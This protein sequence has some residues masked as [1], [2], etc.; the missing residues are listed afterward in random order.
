MTTFDGANL[1][2]TLDAPTGGVLDVNVQED[3][4]SEWKVFVSQSDNSKFPPAFRGSGGDPLTPGVEAGAYFFLRNDL[5][6]R[7]ISS[8]EDQTVNYLGNLVGEDGSTTLINATPGRTVLHLGLQPVTQRV[9][10]I[11]AQNQLGLY[12]AKVHIDTTGTGKALS[13][14]EFPVGTASVPVDNLADALTIADNLGFSHFVFR[15][16]ITL[17]QATGNTQWEGDGTFAF[18]DFNGQDVS[19]TNFSR[20]GCSGVIALPVTQTIL[21]ES[22]SIVNTVTNFSGIISNSTLAAPV[23]LQPGLTRILNCTAD[24]PGAGP[25]S[26]IIDAV[27]NLGIDVA[28]RNYA[29]ELRLENFTQ[30]DSVLAIGFNSGELVIEA[31]CTEFDRVEL[32]GIGHIT[33]NSTVP[34]GI[35]KTIDV[36]GFIEGDDIRLTKQLVAGNAEISSDNLTVTVFDE[37]GVTVLATFS[38][39]ADGKIRTRTS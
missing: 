17:T 24:A 13:G 39:S 29:G 35:G 3:L 33:N 5:G 37:D 36:A 18:V 4:Y 1:L 19:G 38:I 23:I 14:T 32:R 12:D 16:A 11:L 25:T 7:I 31:S 28:V 10:E 20:L 30:S 8:D 27:D 9:D 2:I 15:G 22:S 34:V 6:W 21:I 26:P